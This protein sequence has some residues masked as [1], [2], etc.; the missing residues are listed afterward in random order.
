MRLYQASLYQRSPSTNATVPLA[1]LAATR[2]LTP[3]PFP[4]HT[5]H[6]VTRQAQQTPQN[7]CTTEGDIGILP[8]HQPL[9][10]PLV[11]C[12]AEVTTRHE[13]VEAFPLITVRC[14]EGI[15]IHARSLSW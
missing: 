8:H 11:P 6:R 2:T 1:H 9:I 12:A 14:N 15:K 3:T 5:L 4:P 13:D 7:I 10:A